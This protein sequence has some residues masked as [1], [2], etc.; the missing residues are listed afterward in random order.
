MPREPHS[1]GSPDSL[2][3]CGAEP[4]A[5]MWKDVP[6]RSGVASILLTLLGLFGLVL[7]DRISPQS[8]A[9]SAPQPFEVAVRLFEEVPV[10]PP[11]PPAEIPEASAEEKPRIETPETAPPIVEKVPPVPPPVSKPVPIRPPKERPALPEKKPQVVARRE[12]P[13]TVIPEPSPPSFEHR[14]NPPAAELPKRTAVL[15]KEAAP[16]EPGIAPQQPRAAERGTEAAALPQ[17]RAIVLEP[18]DESEPGV[19]APRVNARYENLADYPAVP[20]ALQGQIEAGIG[21]EDVIPLPKAA[22]FAPAASRK[23]V[24]MLPP[25]ERAETSFAGAARQ[26]EA[27][28][29]GPT[30]RTASFPRSGPAQAAPGKSFDFLDSVGPADL[31]PSVMVSL[32]RLRTCLDPDEE[33]AL[34]ARLAGMLSG[35]GL[36]RSGGV[37]FDIRYPETAYSV[38]V[39][40]YN[41]ERREFP[42]RCAALR[43][44]VYSC[45]ARR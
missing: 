20:T 24:A 40:L 33:L 35:P 26:P 7:L 5:G 27:G 37:V 14:T 29:P 28:L 10:L 11:P 38:H 17:P 31:D 4:L 13:A 30:V 22:G 12:V 25:G 41:Y 32:N 19:A 15:R 2:R 34:R 1:G 21:K 44:A 36:C 45:E 18:S 16:V 8:P 39:D 23:A 3:R 6:W 43:L 9:P 42:D